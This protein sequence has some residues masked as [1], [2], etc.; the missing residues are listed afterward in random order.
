MRNRCTKAEIFTRLV[1]KSSTINYL[2]GDSSVVK[3]RWYQSGTTDTLDPL[4]QVRRAACYRLRSGKFGLGEQIQMK[5]LNPLADLRLL[6]GGL[7]RR[8]NLL[9]GTA[10]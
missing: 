4:L 6:A 9:P 8:T 3:E 5:E 2:A 7:Q 1:L 10:G